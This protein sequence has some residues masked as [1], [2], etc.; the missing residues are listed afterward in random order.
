MKTLG[1]AIRRLSHQSLALAFFVAV[2]LPRLAW[3][4]LDSASTS[5]SHS[6]TTTTTTTETADFVS[7]WR[8]WALLGAVLLVILIIAMSR[9]RSDRVDHTTVVR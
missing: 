9:G 6:A 5:A 7:D 4:Q 2:S 1:L 8:F 3:A